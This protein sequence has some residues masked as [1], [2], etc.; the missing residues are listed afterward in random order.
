MKINNKEDWWDGLDLR[1][2][3]ILEIIAHHI[4]LS[5]EAYEIPGDDTSAS[6]GRRVIEELEYLRKNR[7]SKL[8]RYLNASWCMASDAYAYSVPYWGDFCDLCS[9]D[10]VFEEDEI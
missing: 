7:D 5:H 9:E 4:D 8:H 10:W 3:Y 6:T 1:W 2:E